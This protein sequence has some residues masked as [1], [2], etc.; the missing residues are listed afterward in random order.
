MNYQD[1]AQA[2]LGDV[3]SGNLDAAL[4]RCADDVVFISTR[5]DASDTVAAYGT[6]VGKTGA[7]RFFGIFG[8]TLQAGGIQYPC[9]VRQWPPCGDVRTIE[10]HRQN[11]G[12]PICQRLG[13]HHAF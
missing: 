5:P 10:A 11:N 6:F 13:A 3:F 4:A 9:R 12:T 1:E 7:A 2:F 8:E